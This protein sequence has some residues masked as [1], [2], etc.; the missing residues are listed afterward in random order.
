ME[1][2]VK[3]FLRALAIAAAMVWAAAAEA[4]T[5]SERESPSDAKRNSAV[6]R[7]EKLR[8]TAQAGGDLIQ[9]ANALTL[10]GLSAL[11]DEG[12][13]RAYF[14]Q[15]LKLFER[16]DDPFSRA[17]IFLGLGLSAKERLDEVGAEEF[18]RRAAKLAAALPR[19]FKHAF[20]QPVDGIESLLQAMHK[21]AR[22]PWKPADRIERIPALIEGLARGTLAEILVHRGRFP[23]AEKELERVLELSS[24]LGGALAATTRELLA[25]IEKNRQDPKLQAVALLEESR[26]R[27]IP[28]GSAAA[29]E[30]FL[31]AK[32]LLSLPSEP[33]DRAK[34]LAVISLLARNANRAEEAV[35]LLAEA[36]KLMPSLPPFVH[37]LRSILFSD[38]G[39][40]DR[41]RRAA[42]DASKA[43]ASEDDSKL[44]EALRW[45]AVAQADE[46]E[47]P[48]KMKAL[49]KLVEFLPGLPP[50]VRNLIETF[51][52]M[53]D[54]TGSVDEAR[55]KKFAAALAELLP[56]EGM[57]SS[58]RLLKAF[59]DDPTANFE[60]LATNALQELANLPVGSMAEDDPDRNLILMLRSSLLKNQGRNAEAIAPARELAESSEQMQS[61][62]RLDEFSLNIARETA[63]SF[64]PLIE[65]E[66]AAGRTEDAFESAERA[67]AST[68]L[69]WLGRPRTDPLIR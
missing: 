15:A 1:R 49:K 62:L 43:A 22:L 66:I 12:K 5:V 41:G 54:E 6:E 27:G 39:A 33:E 68:L 37:G 28:L 23:E 45:I 38:L 7:L 19:P 20:F 29:E 47:W 44:A 69:R 36:E 10:L 21:A 4:R 30:L 17:V 24:G 13:S 57:E 16:I 50:E 52:A 42:D 14:E 35:A 18:L 56:A 3:L 64:D 60:T 40:P 59:R 65:L 67:R 55:L 2:R 53:E 51:A 25:F 32:K 61:H 26:M 8:A 11:E 46:S 63:K 31:K 34:T 48:E 58:R 9:K